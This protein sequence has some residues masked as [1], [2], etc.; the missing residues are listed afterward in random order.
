MSEPV[1]ATNARQRGILRLVLL[2]NLVLF[3]GLGLAGWLADS[4]AL[5]ANALDNGADGAVYLISLLAIGRSNRWKAGAATASGVLLLL[6]AAG[7][8]ADVARRWLA[9]AEPL[10]PAMMIMALVAAGVNLWCLILLRKI[11]DDDVNMRAAQT[12]SLNDFVSNGGVLVAGG[13]VLWLDRAWPDIVVGALVALIAAKG[14]LEIL[15]D[16]RRDVRE[17]DEGTGTT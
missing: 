9:G 1:N 17:A 14:G 11:K 12:F 5:L 2:L 7:L 6:F 15:R 16:V 13:L 10:G 8:L 3:A 4:S